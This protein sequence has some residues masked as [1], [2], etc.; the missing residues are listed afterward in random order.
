MAVFDPAQGA[1]IN[2]I[3]HEDGWY[4]ATREQGA[5]AQA[6]DALVLALPAREAADLLEPLLPATATRVFTGAP[7]PEL[8][9]WISAVRV[10][11]CGGWL[12]GGK[13]WDAVLS[14]RAVAARLLND[15]AMA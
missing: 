15:L 13:E 10:G 1:T 6:Y 8:C 12:C 9:I 4:V 11:L 5:H 7:S 14:G 3:W 2:D